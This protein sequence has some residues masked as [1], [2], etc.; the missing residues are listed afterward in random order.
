MIILLILTIYVIYKLY[1]ILGQENESTFFGQK[2]E[3][4]KDI[5]EAIVSEIKKSNQNTKDEIFF[6][7]TK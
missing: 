5:K 4:T 1:K 2:T 7:L 6:Q 3:S